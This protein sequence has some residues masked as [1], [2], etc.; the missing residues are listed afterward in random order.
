MGY[1]LPAT[2]GKVVVDISCGSGLFARRFAASG[3]F[4]GVVAAD[5]SE[6]MLTQVRCVLAG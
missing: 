2:A 6:S 4:A 3:R 1:L 5:F